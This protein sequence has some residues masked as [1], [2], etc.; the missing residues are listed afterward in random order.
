MHVTIDCLG[1]SARWCG[2]ER[3]ALDLPQGSTVADA[4][5]ALAGRHA[6]FGDRR[7]RIAAAIDD[8]LVGPTRALEEGDVIALIPP[9]SG[10]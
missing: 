10:G 4:F 2:A 5:E 6:D 3:L 1:A 8:V 9:V 7:D